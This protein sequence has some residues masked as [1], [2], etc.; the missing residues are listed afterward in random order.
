MQAVLLRLESQGVLR[1]IRVVAARRFFA[2]GN[3][4]GAAASPHPHQAGPQ[5]PAQIPLG[6][7]GSGGA[8]RSSGPIV[9]LAAAWHKVRVGF[10]TKLS[11]REVV[12]C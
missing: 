8:P 9:A 3:S 1:T 11:L 12:K 10:Y 4:R 5:E 2:F 6:R 7:E